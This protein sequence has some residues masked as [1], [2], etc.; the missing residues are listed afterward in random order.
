MPI[1]AIQGDARQPL[2]IVDRLTARTHRE[3]RTAAAATAAE[4]VRLDELFDRTPLDSWGHDRVTLLGDAAHPMLPHA[5][6]G[7]AQAL[8][9]AVALGA[10][11]GPSQ[12]PAAALREY[13]RI[14]T[15]RT[16][17]IVNLSRRN[18]RLFSLEHP[19]ACWL[20]DTAIRLVPEFVMIK[21][22]VALGRH[23]F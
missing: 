12:D 10:T 7:A 21:A 20:R 16:R 19:M 15:R 4:D 18:A 8:E 3:L 1:A 11:L 23:C 2:A 9:D 6:Q 17:A 22:Q 14:R 5:G 13:Q